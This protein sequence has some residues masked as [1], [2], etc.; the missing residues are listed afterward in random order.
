M[1][2]LTRPFGD[3]A[4]AQHCEAILTLMCMVTRHKDHFEHSNLVLL[5]TVRGAAAG[6]KSQAAASTDLSV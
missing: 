6:D 1:P 5:S 4:K 2:G 3:S